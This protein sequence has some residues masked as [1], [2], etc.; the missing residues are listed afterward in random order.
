MTKEPP[1]TI[2]RETV[3]GEPERRELLWVYKL[4][5]ISVIMFAIDSL[6]ARVP[7]LGDQG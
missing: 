7:M 3:P 1:K 6:G 2:S 5:K 4:H